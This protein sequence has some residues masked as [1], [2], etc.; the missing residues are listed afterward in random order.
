MT[1]KLTLIKA[2][3]QYPYYL[4]LM[5]LQ[6]AGKSIQI[7]QKRTFSSPTGVFFLSC[8]HFLTVLVQDLSQKQSQWNMDR[9]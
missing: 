7:T 5:L 4:D 3:Y 1:V 6:L 8:L 2:S 9:G